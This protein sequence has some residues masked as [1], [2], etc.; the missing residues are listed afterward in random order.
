[1]NRCV[2]TGKRPARKTIGIPS[3]A[4]PPQ[5]PLGGSKRISA[6]AQDQPSSARGPART[7]SQTTPPPTARGRS[8]RRRTTAEAAAADSDAGSTG[9][10]TG[11]DSGDAAA[12]H[13]TEGVVHRLPS[14]TDFGNREVCVVCERTRP[15][16]VLPYCYGACESCATLWVHCMKF[17]LDLDE[18]RRVWRSR[19]RQVNDTFPTIA[20]LLKELG[21]LHSEKAARK[22]WEAA[23]NVSALSKFTHK[24][25][26]VRANQPKHRA[27]AGSAAAAGAEDSGTAT[28]G[29]KGQALGGGSQ[30]KHSSSAAAAANESG[31][32]PKGAGA[33]AAH[34]QCKSQ[35]GSSTGAAPGSAVQAAALPKASST[36]G[37]AADA[38]EAHTPQPVVASQQSQGA[39]SSM[40]GLGGATAAMK[41]LPMPSMTDFGPK[42]ECVI[43]GKV[44]STCLLPHA[45]GACETCAT[46]WVQCQ[47]HGLVV[48][49]V[50]RVWQLGKWA[51]QY[52]SFVNAARALKAAGALASE[53]LAKAALQSVGGSVV[54]LVHYQEGD[55]EE[56]LAEQAAEAK[57][58]AKAAKQQ[59][60]P[61][62]TPEKNS[63]EGSPEA[64][65]EPVAA[66]HKLK[67]KRPKPGPHHPPGKTFSLPSMQD[68]GP[69]RDCVV[70]KIHRAT[71][72]LPDAL[73][74][75]QRC[76]V[77][78]IQCA[79]YGC[80]IREVRRLYKLQLKSPVTLAQFP[81]IARN[82]KEQGLLQSNSVAK[83]ALNLCGSV[84]A[85]A[86]FQMPDS[87]YE[88]SDEE[89]EPG[90]T[91]GVNISVNLGMNNSNLG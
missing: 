18:V 60:P 28:A 71:C 13:Q 82:M 26:V 72:T 9:V 73:G 4:R 91:T 70:C 77:L 6:A 15:I 24:T 54:Q 56:V 90:V 86:K 50:K 85:L 34:P 29:G 10:A 87:E 59:Q 40:S 3:D 46:L 49:E 21:V 14:M 11:A 61:S 37:A 65:P 17:G 31:A 47:R 42:T 53:E 1:M 55:A 23:G 5:H 35:R 62:P 58:A 57:R 78:C 75:C 8:Q 63:S 41:S 33:T 7:Q 36:T 2:G 44:R 39:K 89:E 81:N 52:T 51:G 68:F 22:V 27:T 12:P 25:P 88:D 79:R 32:P 38:S 64:A 45:M 48:E 74:A 19:P 76:A 69:K 67:I 43:C 16:C 20:R 80:T 84:G 30:L 83:R 66:T